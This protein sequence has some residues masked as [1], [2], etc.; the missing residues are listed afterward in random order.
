[1]MM[2]QR[3]RKQALL[4]LALTVGMLTA[5]ATALWAASATALRDVNGHWAQQAIVQL[6]QNDVI[7]GY[8][9]G[10]FRPDGNI[11]RSEFA[12]IL[13]RALRLNVSQGAG[14][15]SSRFNDVS[16]SFWAAPVIDA[17]T[18]QGLMSGYPGGLFYPNK[19]ISRAEAMTVLANAARLSTPNEVRAEELLRHFQDA[20]QVPAWARRS[21]AAAVEARIFAND[22]Q[23]SN[24]IEPTQSA[25]RAD[26]A[27]MMYNTLA[28]NP[29]LAADQSREYNR[30][31]QQWPNPTP[32]EG[33][34]V[35]RQPANSAVVA[36]PLEGPDGMPRTTL[37]GRVTTVPANTQFVGTLQSAINSEEN[38]VGDVVR[39][40]LTEGLFSADGM[41][42]V[43]AGSTVMGRVAEVV[44][45]GRAGRN[46]R[47]GIDFNQILTPDGRRFQIQAEV[48]SE[49]NGVLVGGSASGRALKAAGK[50]AIGAGLGAALGTAMGPLSGGKV[51]KGA[52]Y[53]TAIGAGA[54]AVA[55]AAGKGQPVE[56]TMGERL[57]I[58]LEQPLTVEVVNASQQQP[59]NIVSPGSS[60]QYA[61]SQQGQ[62]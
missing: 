4:S 35:S 14:A 9:D 47:V 58:K 33:V 42:V 44:P 36:L 60:V 34:Q 55:A 18:R 15:P 39:L 49:N 12:A 54:G 20:A 37:Q 22:P 28:G 2:N 50:T 51:G 40:T 23:E 31:Q 46:G 10:T 29:Q 24:W 57:E 21:V 43:P 56:L 48:N 59:N 25:T 1:M 11:T 61:P 27:A 13:A 32:A 38:Q 19:N 41:P 52:I 3:S 8:P 45:T 5:P 62:W 30:T 17:V 53:G 26:V 16:A 7:G 6:N